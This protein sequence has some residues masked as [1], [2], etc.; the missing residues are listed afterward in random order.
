MLYRSA[1][2]CNVCGGSLRITGSRCSN[3]C[4]RYCHARYCE[5]PGHSLDLERARERHR[6]R[7]LALM[8]DAEAPSG[9]A[10][11]S[12]DRRDSSAE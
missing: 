9:P 2:Y 12:G 11:D 8:R 10:D 4:C 1:L 5:G 6:A 7:L 3:R